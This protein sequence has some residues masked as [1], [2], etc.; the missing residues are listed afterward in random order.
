MCKLNFGRYGRNN[1][2]A[3]VH[4]SKFFVLASVENQFFNTYYSEDG[5][6]WKEPNQ[7]CALTH[8]DVHAAVSHGQYIMLFTLGCHNIGNTIGEEEVSC[9]PSGNNSNVRMQNRIYYSKDGAT[10]LLARNPYNLDQN[11]N[12]PV[13]RAVPYQSRDDDVPGGYEFRWG[14][15]PSKS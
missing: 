15:V 14:Y 9:Q 7:A 1:I 5:L 2:F 10:W 12:E 8:V 6:Q 13:S 4:N 3:L 11:S